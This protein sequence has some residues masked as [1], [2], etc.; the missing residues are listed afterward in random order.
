M[1]IKYSH[2][3]FSDES[4]YNTG[5][6][7]SIGMVSMPFEEL[8]SIEN[9]ILSICNEFNISR[10]KNLKWGQLKN[11]KKR[12]CANNIITYIVE[13]AIKEKLRVDVLVWDIQD[14]RHKVQGRD[15]VQNLQRMYYH[16]MKNIFIE[17]WPG[18]NFWKILPD[19]NCALDWN[20][21]ALYLEHK[22]MVSAIKKSDK[23]P[24][25]SLELENM[26]FLD[27]IEADS[28]DN[29][30]IQVADFFAG[31]ARYSREKYDTY[32][33]WCIQKIGQTRFIPTNIELS[34]ADKHRCFIMSNF[35][36]ICKS[37]SLGVSLRSS[38]GFKTFNPNNRINFW[39][40]IPKSDKDKAPTRL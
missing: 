13:N 25:L 6:Y 23:S 39:F 27:I 19:Q 32:D 5:R 28:S 29:V 11:N 10:L 34:N 2:C 22:S 35:D 9:K 1:K 21:M 31:M 4:G 38:K 14:S 26:C 24:K 40:Y 8:S 17:R 33:E 3:A 20:D 30:L 16:L 15:D 37:K 36:S 18:V 12:D 7:R